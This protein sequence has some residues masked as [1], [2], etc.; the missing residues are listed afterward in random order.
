ML[1]KI[2][3]YNT[4]TRRIEEFS[5][6]EKGIVKIYVCGPT[7]YD[8]NHIGHGKTYV[9]FDA[10]KRYLSLRG[11]HVVHVMNI[12]DID[13]K[14]INRAREENCDWREIVDTY[15]KDYMV[16]LKKLNV[17][18]DIHPRVTEHIKEIIEFIQILIDKGYAYVTP[19]GNVYFEV[20]KY[21]DYGRL[22]NRL[23]KTL[24]SQETEFLSE[25]KKPYDFALWKAWKPGEPY[26]EAPWGKGRPG[27]HIECS[28]MST[29][30]LGRQFDIHG[31]GTDLIFPHHENERAQSEAAL[32]VNPW[33]KYWVHV[34]MVM[35]G[36]E[37]MSKSLGNIIP[38]REAFKKW[39]PEPLR[40]WYFMGHYRKPQVFTEDSI[41][42]AIKLYDRLVSAF[43]L[44]KKLMKEATDP[45]KADDK[46][47]NLN[48]ELLR[49]H[50]EFHEALS[51]N[52]NTPK[53]LAVINKY[54]NLL[55]S[56][57]QYN[58][59]PLLI[60]RAYNLLKEYNHVL[61]V[62]DKYFEETSS[63]YESLVD[64]LINIIV[65][66]RKELRRRKLYELADRIRSELGK[67]GVVLMDRGE[68]TIWLKKK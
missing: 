59:H 2:R 51:D 19:S 63:E 14:I 21:P 34:G 22:S 16:S 64:R 33:V 15:T 60:Y 68:E 6:L 46:I 32:G 7:V 36:S 61:G 20:D 3:I 45:F 12:T 1:P 58:P 54:L 67:E 27:W 57:I 24:W 62:L 38:L 10:L 31:G 49:L 18:I 28:V 47:V 23:E 29:K 30:Y 42:Q 48:N 37:K 39:G 53:A 56:K 65:D 35:V 41:G 8:Y 44:L 9:V 17:Q 43:N 50:I 26:W 40:L 52:F 13:D 4:L 5:P 55:F 25:K 11:Y 66:I